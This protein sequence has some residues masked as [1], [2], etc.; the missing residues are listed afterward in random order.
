MRLP[1][2]ALLLLL[3]LAGCVSPKPADTV[4]QAALGEQIAPPPADVA[5]SGAELWGRQS[6]DVR[7]VVVSGTHQG[8]KVAVRRKREIKNQWIVEYEGLRTS[9][10]QI[11]DDGAVHL[12]SDEDLDSQSRVTYDPPL[13]L[14]PARLT[15]DE[16]TPARSTTMTVTNLADRSPRDRGTCRYR[17]FVRGKQTI[18]T[19][20]GPVQAWI[21]VCVRELELSMAKGTVTVLTAYAPRGG[22]IAERTDQQLRA[23]GLFPIRKQQELMLAP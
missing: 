4:P 13:E 12:L 18:T 16:N 14:L 15:A 2:P 19:P 23:V 20:K 8:R 6:G 11:G 22:M 21:V 1:W 3:I 5:L 17:V 10:L 9:H 7:L